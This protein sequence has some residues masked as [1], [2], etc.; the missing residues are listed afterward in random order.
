M[1]LEGQRF[2]Q[3]KPGTHLL[4]AAALLEIAKVMEFGAQKYTP[5]NY[6][7]GL[8]WSAYVGSMLRHVYA[9]YLGEELD[10]ESG[11]HH[12]AHAGCNVLMVL[13]AVMYG[14]GEDD[15]WEAPRGYSAL[16]KELNS[17]E[18]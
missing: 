4:P 15:R 9:W 11:Y 5:H 1:A 7:K 2:N 16:W 6:R 14:H 17:E 8:S 13:D 18:S 12:L 3:G 10:E